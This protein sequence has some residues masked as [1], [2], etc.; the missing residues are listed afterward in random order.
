MG[1]RGKQKREMNRVKKAEEEE[2]EEKSG[3]E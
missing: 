2:V 3:R 1:R